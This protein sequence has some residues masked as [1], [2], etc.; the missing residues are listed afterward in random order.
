MRS[1][2]SI[3]ILTLVLLISVISF[4]AFQI[5]SHYFE[6]KIYAESERNINS[7]LTSLDQLMDQF[8]YSDEAHDGHIGTLINRMEKEERVLH[9]LL[10]DSTG[11]LMHFLYDDTV[12]NLKLSPDL[13]SSPSKGI[14]FEFF[15]DT[16]P[17]FSRVYIPLQNEPSCNGSPP[18]KDE[19]LGSL[20]IDIR[21][22]NPHNSK[23]FI[24]TASIVFTSAMV[25]IILTFV[26]LIHYRFVH[27]SLHDFNRTIEAVNKGELQSRLSI[28]ET[29]ELG[30]LGTSFNNM[31]HTF[32]KATKELEDFHRKELR[33]NY[34]LATIGEMAARL[35]HEIRNPITGIANAIEIIVS[36]TNDKHN[37]PILEEV[38]RQ[39][40]RV[41]EAIT[42]LLKY[43]RKKD[44]N[45]VINNIN[46]L[47]EQ[48]VFFLKSQLKGKEIHFILDPGEDIPRFR[49]DREQLEDVLLNLGM[50]A[51]RAI[52]GNG[53]I[54]FRTEFNHDENSVNIFVID[55]G[56]GIPEENL[57]NLFHPFFTTYNEGTGLGLAIVKDIIRKHEGKIWANNN[58][59][60]GA[61]FTISL[62]ANL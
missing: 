32:Q 59:T 40:N 34:K 12:N 51:I 3:I 23:T 31:L 4:G 45:L 42:S 47:T 25:L 22:D 43:S 19:N 39:A 1:F 33:S 52:S 5:Y 9:T 62:P 7:T 49:F 60:G 46:E 58:K 28:P 15:T 24:R 35:A 53:S 54:T 29:R 38:Q 11:N 18:S 37:L 41:N 55:T 27:K 16:K 21:L 26:F 20:L 56:K 2:R 57:S 48:L 44:L 17:P 14:R 36:E 13:L 50:N 10:I 61:I 8:C 6:G 30:Q